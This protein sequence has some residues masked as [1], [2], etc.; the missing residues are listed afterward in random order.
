MWPDK[1]TRQ[2]NA[3]PPNPSESDYQGPYNKLLNTLFPPDSDFVVVP[4]YLLDSRNSADFVVMFEILLVNKPVLFLELKPPSHL[5]LLSKHQAAD[6]HIRSRM[7]DVVATCPLETLYAV[8]ALGGR[9]CF[10]S[11][12][13]TDSDA[14]I[15]PA[16]PRHPTKMNDTAPADRWACDIL[17]STGEERLRQIVQKIIQ[18]C[19]A[20]HG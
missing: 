13:T 16:I 2:F 20:L 11:L 4:Q 1:I 6:K 15:M 17:E 7:T 19:A 14:E 8:S 18:E 9:L 5:N 12:D 3:I 10:Y